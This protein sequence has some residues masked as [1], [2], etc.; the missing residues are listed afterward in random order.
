VFSVVLSVCFTSHTFENEDTTKL[1]CFC[2]FYTYFKTRKW[3]RRIIFMK[4]LSVLT[5]MH[6]IELW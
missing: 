5:E 6:V 4:G 1:E 2:D 3:E